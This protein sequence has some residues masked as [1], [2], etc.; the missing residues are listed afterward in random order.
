LASG[1]DDTKIVIWQQDSTAKQSFGNAPTPENYRPIKVLMGHE[2]DV[3]DLQWSPDQQ[4][5]ASCGFDSKIFIWDGTT[6]DRI[7]AISTHTA[8]V[9]GLAW[10][11]AGSFLATQVD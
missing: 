5:L 1:S 8:F 7:T 4:Y 9:K 3:S 2:S 6:F 11:P 10:D